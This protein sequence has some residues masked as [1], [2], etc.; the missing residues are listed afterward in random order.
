ME[1]QYHIEKMNG[2]KPEISWGKILER[3]WQKCIWNMSAKLKIYVLKYRMTLN[4]RLI[5]VLLDKN[6]DLIYT[7]LSNLRDKNKEWKIWAGTK[8]KA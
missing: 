6:A 3:K 4:W 2:R 1:T 8:Y 5:N 7:V